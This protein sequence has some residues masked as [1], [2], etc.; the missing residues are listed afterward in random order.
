MP[1]ITML[2]DFGLQEEYVAVMKGVVLSIQ[3]EVV[4]VDIS[5]QI[6]S[7]DV[8]QAAFAIFSAYRFFPAGSVHL[9]VVDPGVGTE[10]GILVLEAAEHIFIAPDNGVLTLLI[11][12]I[13]P[14]ALFRLSDKS[15][16]RHPVCATFHGRDVM[17]PVAAHIS[18]GVALEKIGI[19]IDPAEAVHL[20]DLQAGIEANGVLKG[21]V[22]TIDRFGNLITNIDSAIL[23][24]VC[25][26]ENARRVQVKIG[27][28]TIRGLSRTYADRAPNEL[29]ALVGSR[30]YLEV[31]AN[32]GS[33]AQ[34]LKVKKGDSVSL[35]P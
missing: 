28:R 22:I 21:R 3:P 13:E 25:K 33:A 4:L 30:G 31:A 1:V 16:Y 35:I 9:V 8:V 24:R 18:R 29:T 27:P 5:H 15:F 14:L 26:P 2:T 19:P 17:A 6:E 34:M 20:E 12:K 32:R 23:E 7:Q 11:D 10:R